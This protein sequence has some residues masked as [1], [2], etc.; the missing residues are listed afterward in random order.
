V[1]LLPEEEKA[2][3]QRGTDN[4]DAYNLFLMARQTYAAGY[5]AD[6]RRL[7]A[8][9][10]ICRRA[11]DIDAN[12]ADAWALIALAEMLLRSNVG[13]QGGDG[14][15]AAAE[16]ALALN[17]DLAEAH[18]VKAR[19][20]SEENRIADARREIDSA[21]RLN[22]ESYQVNRNAG[23][24][25]FRQKQLEEAGAY[26]EKAMTVEENDFGSG[27]MLVTV[28]TAL[29]KPEAAQ[30][31]AKI[32]LERCEKVLARDSNN[33]AAL[34]HSAVAL[35]TLGQR[36]RAK[37]RMEYALLVDPD[38]LTMR[39]NFVC[40]LTNYLG[41]KDAALEMFRPALEQ[42]GGLG[43]INHAKVDPDLDRIRDDPRF[44]EMLAAAERRLK[45][46]SRDTKK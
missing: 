44:K 7:D 23:L 32:T 36:D 15:L 1:K 29:G 25:S 40:A 39:Y 9:I 5:E 26:W 37:E 16:R 2:I 34:G 4:V 27:G 11:V 33:G 41:D 10:R 45:S 31:A 38:N 12:Y 28:Y 20:L 21:L 18:A 17:P 43:L 14:G 8:I 13:G 24:L 19:I 35:A 3:E 22:P 46:A 30:R 42:M 6:A